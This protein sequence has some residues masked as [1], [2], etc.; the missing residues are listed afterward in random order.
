MFG[1]IHGRV[2]RPASK[3][4]IVSKT[5]IQLVIF[6]TIFLAILPAGFYVLESWLGLESYRFGNS[7]VTVC[8]IILFTLGGTLGFT[9]GLMMSIHGKGTPLPMDCA[10]ELVIVG[11][12]RYI[13][14]PMAVAGLTQG[15]AV[16]MILGSPAV[17][18]YAIC[19]GPIW[20]IFVRPW[21][22][23]D[24][25]QRFGEPYRQYRTAVKCWLPRLRGVSVK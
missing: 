8:G 23:A 11:P 21:E 13:R 16:G 19:G 6:W 9:S 1:A 5:L 15:I 22:E 18:I 20:H 3:G 12:Y 25:D 2:A 17:I 24:L 14:N 4:W 10:R 7:A